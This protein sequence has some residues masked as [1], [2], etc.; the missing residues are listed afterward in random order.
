M[1]VRGLKSKIKDIAALAEDQNLD[2][3]IF[4]ETK[5]KQE[6]TRKLTGYKDT[7]LNRDTE[8]GGVIIYTKKDM[9]TELIKKNKECETIWIKING[10]KDSLVIGG[11]YS[12]CEYTQPKKK[13]GD[14]VKNIE[15]YRKVWL[16]HF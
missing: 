5:L 1:N 3:M 8:A 13:I 7:I 10:K 14:I 4:T 11:T 15:N 2:V 16:C 6:E 9:K 12:P